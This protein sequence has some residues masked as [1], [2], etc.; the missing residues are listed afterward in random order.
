MERNNIVV[1]RS[2]NFAL[3]II[4][5]VNELP[6][7]RTCDIISRQLIRSGTSIGANVEEA[8]S[9]YSRNDFASK[10]SIAQ[11]EAREANYWL[12]LLMDSK[13][14]KEDVI[15]DVLNESEEISKILFSIVRSSKKGS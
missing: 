8:Q 12:R 6:K 15:R 1:K 11:K 9:G 13:Q 14:L 2:Y 3:S 4:K 7:N 10:M 5:L